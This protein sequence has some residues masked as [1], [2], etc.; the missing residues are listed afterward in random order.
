[1]D[2]GPSQE[3]VLELKKSYAILESLEKMKTY[4]HRD[5][6]RLGSSILGMKQAAF[7]LRSLESTCDGEEEIL[8]PIGGGVFIRGRADPHKK[9]IVKISLDLSVERSIAGAVELLDERREGFEKTFEGVAEK[10]NE[11]VE[12][13]NITIAQITELEALYNGGMK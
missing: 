5:R 2:D 13:E 3:I 11:V 1:M 6:E 8:I 4:L 7:T 12:K 10:F 9:V